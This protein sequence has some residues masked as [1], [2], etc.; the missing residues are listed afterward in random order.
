MRPACA[1]EVARRVPPAP[2]EIPQRRDADGT[3][4]PQARRKRDLRRLGGLNPLTRRK[5]IQNLQ[6]LQKIQTFQFKW[7]SVAK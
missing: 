1:L 2:N 5:C 7:K 6:N 4:C 3:S